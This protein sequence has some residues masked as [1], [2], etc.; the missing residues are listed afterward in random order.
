VAGLK[1]YSDFLKSLD[2]KDC[3]AAGVLPARLFVPAGLF[4]MD[5][6]RYRF[7]SRYDKKLLAALV[8]LRG[9]RNAFNLLKVYWAN[10]I[11]LV[12]TV[13]IPEAIV[14]AAIKPDTGYFIFC[15]VFSALISYS[16]D[17]D[18]YKK[19]KDRR[20][21]LKSDFPDFAGKLVLLV[22]AGMTITKAWEKA[23]LEGKP[24]SPLYEELKR[25]LTDIKGGI[26]EHRAYEAFAKRCRVPEITRFV[27]LI[28]QNLRKGNS[29]LIPLMRLFAGEC[30][31]MRKNAARKYGEEA[32][33]KLLLPMM[34]MFLAILLIVGTPAVLALRG[35]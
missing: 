16:I 33:T 31:E 27:S 19:V 14:A 7:N 22:N 17:R 30:W 11:A 35:I 18:L 23:A 6:L 26:P 3:K 5:L 15:A 9:N 25:S 2:L 29:E 28:L 8:E 20:N 10:K 32:S 24:N 12:F 4:V 1:K 13:L 21:K 34:L